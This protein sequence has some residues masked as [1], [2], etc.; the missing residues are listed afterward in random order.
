MALRHENILHTIGN[1]PIV[2]INKLAPEG[3]NG[4]KIFAEI[5]LFQESN[6]QMAVKI[7]FLHQKFSDRCWS[8]SSKSK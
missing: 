6:M 8:L 4:Y 5:A 2:R 7:W 1:T 3:L